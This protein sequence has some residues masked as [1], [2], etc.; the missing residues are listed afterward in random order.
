MPGESKILNEKPDFTDN[1]F[2]KEINSVS[3]RIKYLKK[4][5]EKSL[6]SNCDCTK[7][8]LEF[9]LKRL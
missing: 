5:I 9:L 4:E 7:E 8:E 6:I 2:I 3:L 1:F